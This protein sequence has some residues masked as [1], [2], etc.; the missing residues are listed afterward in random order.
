MEGGRPRRPSTAV[1]SVELFNSFDMD[2]GRWLSTTVTVGTWVLLQT[3]RRKRTGNEFV[4][5]YKGRV[6]DFRMSQTGKTVKEVL[7][8]HAYM[9]SELRL[10]DSPS[11]F[12][13]H[14]PNCE[15]TA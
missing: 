12:P 13:T 9:H 11:G 2:H 1:K 5:S 10:R 7:I 8:E 4:N 15:L 6:K 14:R 3:R